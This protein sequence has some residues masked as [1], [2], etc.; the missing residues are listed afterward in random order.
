MPPN[1][2]S[3]II[4]VNSRIIRR[5]F[6]NCGRNSGKI[7]VDSSKFSGK[8]FYLFIILFFA[9]QNIMWSVS[10]LRYL[11]P[12]AR[13][14]EC[15]STPPPPPPPR[16]VFIYIYIFFFC[17]RGFGQ[18]G[19]K[20]CVPLCPPPQMNRFH[21]PYNGPLHAHSICM[22]LFMFG[23]ARAP[24]IVFSSIPVLGYRGT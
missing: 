20:M 13:V 2:A 11:F 24:E 18:T 16:D 10:P 8:P 7:R 22:F 12:G 6:G 9:C 14:G 23:F 5:N 4:R 21:P 19:T 15:T 17:F 3:V 1:V